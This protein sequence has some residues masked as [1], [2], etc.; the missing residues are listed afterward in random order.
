MSRCWPSHAARLACTVASGPVLT[1]VVVMVGALTPGYNPWSDTVSRLGSAGQPLATIARAG[2]ILYG[3]LVLIG[4]TSLGEH[5]PAR[6]RCLASLVALYAAGAITA[7]I[8]P[9]DRPSGPHTVTSRIHVLATL[10]GGVAIIAA[11]LVVASCSRSAIV[12]RRSRAVA[13]ACC[14]GAVA[15]K[16]SWGSPIYGFVERVL[17]VLAASWLAALAAHQLGQARSTATAISSR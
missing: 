3:A 9:K 13:V 11:M 6:A 16:F 14:V 8:A 12:R 2:L 10:A 15:F 5:V 1:G 17:L 4:A 7:G